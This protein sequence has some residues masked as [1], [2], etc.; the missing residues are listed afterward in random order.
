MDGKA[1]QSVVSTR[2]HSHF[3][4]FSDINTGLCVHQHYL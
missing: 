4:G 3:M 1:S 2:N